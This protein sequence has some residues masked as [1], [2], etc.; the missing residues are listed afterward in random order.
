[1]VTHG[2]A[3]TSEPKYQVYHSAVL[4]ADADA[5]WEVMRDILQAVEISFGGA[6]ENVQ[7]K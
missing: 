7:W 5:A 3:R 2:Q 1:M 4:A 6:V